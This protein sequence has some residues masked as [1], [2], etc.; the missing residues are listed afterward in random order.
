M[1][2]SGLNSARNFPEMDGITYTPAI[3]ANTFISFVFV[4]GD[5]CP[6]QK[7]VFLF[8]SVLMVA[9]SIAESWG[10]NNGSAV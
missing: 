1:I 5:D 3:G 6:V 7:N 4:D 8:N 9:L 10:F 2:C